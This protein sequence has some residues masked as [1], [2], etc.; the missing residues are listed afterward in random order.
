[1]ERFF[2]LPTS[3]LTVR[4][5]EQQRNWHLGSKIEAKE[6]AAFLNASIP[7]T[8]AEQPPPAQEIDTFADI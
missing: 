1:M 8:Q 6:L 3:P 5:R 4:D 2:L 7:T